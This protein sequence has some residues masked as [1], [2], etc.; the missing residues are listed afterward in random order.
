MGKA[1]LTETSSGQTAD[2]EW[3]LLTVIPGREKRSEK[4]SKKN[5]ERKGW[6][7]QEMGLGSL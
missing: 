3:V 1:Y 7:Q 2:P 5:Q 6:V 4:R